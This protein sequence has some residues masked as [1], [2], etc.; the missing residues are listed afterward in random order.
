[1]C[2]VRLMVSTLFA[3]SDSVSKG[4]VSTSASF[5]TRPAQEPEPRPLFRLLPVPCHQF[6]GGIIQH[7]GRHIGV[8]AVIPLTPVAVCADRYRRKCGYPHV[9][10]SGGK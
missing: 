6:P 8:A 5:P 4:A 9:F 7:Q 10:N 2:I 1:M 3:A